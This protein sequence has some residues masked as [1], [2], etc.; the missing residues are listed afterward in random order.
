MLDPALT[1]EKH[2]GG[3]RRF[4][5]DFNKKLFYRFEGLLY[6]CHYLFFFKLRA[7]REC[8]IYLAL[9]KTGKTDVFFTSMTLLFPSVIGV[10]KDRSRVVA[11][12]VMTQGAAFNTV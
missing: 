12:T 4:S 7:R 2:F 10:G 11:A 9:P 6:L 5:K 8:F 3:C 1:V